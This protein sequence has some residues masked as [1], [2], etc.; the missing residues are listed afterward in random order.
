MNKI[1]K[2]ATIDQ[3]IE[4]IKSADQFGSVQL[5]IKSVGLDLSTLSETQIDQM[6]G[7]ESAWEKTPLTEELIAYNFSAETT[8]RKSCAGFVQAE[9]EKQGLAIPENASWKKIS[10][11]FDT[12][13]L[14]TVD[15]QDFI[16]VVTQSWVDANNLIC[17]TSV[18]EK[19]P[20]TAEI[21]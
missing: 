4:F 13:C 11:K 10:L 19:F 20:T 17:K 7:N 6:I 18:G 21:A 2:S 3:K 14:S 5:L 12:F 8:E 9:I 1:A 16:K 15:E